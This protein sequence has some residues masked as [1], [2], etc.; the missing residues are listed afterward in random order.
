[1]GW[2]AFVGFGI[3]VIGVPSEFLPSNKLSTFSDLVRPSVNYFIG[4]TAIELTRHRSKAQDRRQAS[5]Q[6]LI[7]GPS[8]P[9]P[10]LPLLTSPLLSDPYR[11]IL[12]LVRS[13]DR[14]DAGQERVRTHMD[15]QRLDQPILVDQSLG[16]H[17]PL[18]AFDL[19]LLLCQ[20]T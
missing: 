19:F 13:F 14:Q 3:L 20:S 11:Q 16:Y 4:K 12:R 18:D 8:S 15:D 7:S 6:E 17:C 2:S 9:L 1:M 5:F 10:V